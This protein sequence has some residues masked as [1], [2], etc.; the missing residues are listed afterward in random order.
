[1]NYFASTPQ[2]TVANETWVIFH[3]KGTVGS[4]VGNSM[5]CSLN[6]LKGIL[7]GSTMGV[8]RGMLGM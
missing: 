5:S 6:S 4:G 3:P 7:W 2:G 1:M 8:R